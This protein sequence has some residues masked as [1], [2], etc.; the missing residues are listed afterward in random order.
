M[1]KVFHSFLWLVPLAIAF[2]VLVVFLGSLGS[3]KYT[4]ESK[5]LIDTAGFSYPGIERG[6]ETERA[7]LDE[8]GVESQVQLMRSAD[9]AR[10]VVQKLD[11]ADDSSFAGGGEPGPISKALISLGLREDQSQSSREEAAVSKLAGALEVYRVKGSRVISV[12]FTSTDPELAAVI[13]N[14]VVREYRALQETTKRTASDSAAAALQPQMKRLQKEVEAAERK[15]AEFRASADLLLGTSSQTLS[16]QQLSE[17]SSQVSAAVAQRLEAEARAQLIKR[18]LETGGNLESASEVLNSILI[19]RL[20]ERQIELQ[21]RIAELSTTLL[22]GHPQIKGLRSQ[23]AGYDQQIRSEA[24]KIMQGLENDAAIAGQRV[25]D[26]NKQLEVLKQDAARS[27]S[28][29]V[30]LQELE[31]DAKAK[32]AQLEAVRARLRDA[33]LLQGVG[34][35][36]ADSRVISRATVPME[37]DG[38]KTTLLAALS[39]FAFLFIGIIG[40]AVK[41]LVNG[42]ALR[43]ESYL[44]P[45]PKQSRALVAR[46][47]E[48]KGAT[49]MVVDAVRGAAGS[50]QN[51]LLSRSS[52][53]DA[54]TAE[55]EKQDE[56]AEEF[57]RDAMEDAA[58]LEN[59]EMPEAIQEASRATSV[60][61]IVVLSVDS[62]ALSNKVAFDCTR[63]IAEGGIMPLF[64]E[65]RSDVYT[66]NFDDDAFSDEELNYMGRDLHDQAPGFSEL[67]EGSAAFTNVI[68]RDPVSRAHVIEAGGV[69]ID[70][71]VVQN[72]RYSLIMEALDLTYDVIVAD[73]GLIEPSLICA[74][75]LSEADRVIV[76]TD[77]SPAGPELERALSVLE[78]H[79]GAPVEVERISGDE[80]AARYN[81]D[82]AA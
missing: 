67:L 37:A 43:R 77:G 69:R 61:R 44:V 64:L 72:G 10:Q 38:I 17:V 53:S 66:P 19:Q 18:L 13:A 25:A 45:R 47:M 49:E 48:K 9:L 76:A 20:R 21:T 5:V 35:L 81:S 14:E 60:R 52:A 27:G 3:D 31:R 40:V 54:K 34:V 68:H 16:Q 11:L 65:V 30:K 6:I 70:D 7:L 36:H 26:L 41:A 28:D 58:G 59:L 57:A 75:M 1:K 74:Q 4:A 8:E 55:E 62:E 63:K 15:V 22:P 46:G 71:S 2:S 33:E 80:V 56:A 24:R 12:N 51:R 73:L 82:M 39:A 78:Q 32:A 42:D 79:T 50:F 23:L 29:T